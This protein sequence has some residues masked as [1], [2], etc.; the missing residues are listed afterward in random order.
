MRVP[1]VLVRELSS[2]KLSELLEKQ[3][4]DIAT[5]DFPRYEEASSHFIKEYLNGKYGS[6]E[7]VSPYS[8]SMFYALD[9]YEAAK[10]VR[11]ALAEGKVVL[12]NRY[13]GSNMAHQG[14][15]F[16]NPEERRGFFI[17][18]DNLEFEMLNIPRPTK[19]FVLR[20][21]AATAQ[22]LVDKKETREYTDKKRDIHEADI[23]HMERAVSV[24]DDLCELFP[25]DFERIDCVRSDKLLD[26]E[27]IH[28]M[29]LEKVTPMLPHIEKQP[30]K[31]AEVDYVKKNENGSFSVTQ[32]GK[33]FLS[34]AVTNTDDNVYVFHRRKK[35]RQ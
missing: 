28:K 12:A 13:T 9:R 7:E 29:I 31:E 25:K 23:S 26:I 8:A 34:E 10:D 33:D 2:K 35:L 22:Q 21:P 4:Y 30:Q 3:G 32:A 5:F 1:T 6:A 17:W 18:L 11:K 15:K 20:V 14:T 27:T 19:S 24:Y 16:Y